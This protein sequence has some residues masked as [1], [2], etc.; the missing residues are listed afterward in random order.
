M[1]DRAMLAALSNR[2]KDFRPLTAEQ[3]RSIDAWVSAELVATEEEEVSALVKS[4]IYAAERVV[5]Q[6]LWRAVHKGPAVPPNLERSIL[7]K[8]QQSPSRPRV[9]WSLRTLRWHWA[10]L[11]GAVAVAVI[12]VAV[13]TFQFRRGQVTAPQIQLAMA[14]IAD[15]SAL[16]EPSSIRMQEALLRPRALARRRAFRD[17]SEVPVSAVKELLEAVT[18]GTAGSVPQA[19]ADALVHVEGPIS[20]G[21]RL[22]VDSALKNRV[23]ATLERG[24]I[25]LRFYDLNDLRTNDFRRSLAGAL[26]AG[27]AY[28]LTI[29]AVAQYIASHRTTRL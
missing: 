6:R 1:T 8:Y 22:F 27:P 20:Q 18:R 4:N 25:I 13:G 12:V 2:R 23:E 14:T 19:I 5:E 16:F 3:V 10:A 21:S 7:S 17:V 15:R 28:L 9:W 24:R 29:E 26:E 11:A